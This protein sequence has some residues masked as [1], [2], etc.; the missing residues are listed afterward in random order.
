M[1]APPFLSSLKSQQTDNAELGCLEV[2]ESP[3]LTCH[4]AILIFSVILE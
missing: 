2:Y 1:F 3:Y 4:H